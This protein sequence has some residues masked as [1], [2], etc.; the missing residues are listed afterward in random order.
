[1]LNRIL[2]SSLLVLL[3]ACGSQPPR[4]VETREEGGTVLKPSERITPPAAVKRGGGY[5][6]D[7]GPGDDEPPPEVLAAI[8]DAVPRAE[9]LHRFA[10]KPY[11]VLGKDYVPLPPGRTYKVN[12]IASWYGKKF[13]G[14]KTSSGE[15]YDM[16]GMTAA[17]TVLPIP[18]YVRVTAQGSGKSVVLRVNDRGPFHADRIIDL[19]YTAAWKLGLI[20][21]GSGRVTVELLDPSRELAASSAPA[22]SEPV[23]ASN[24]PLVSPPVPA[25]TG[26]LAPG[27]YVQLGAFGNPDNAEAFRNHM[28]REFDWLS[29]RLQ[30]VPGGNVMR[31]QAGPFATRAEAEALAEKV[32]T[33]TGVKPTIVTR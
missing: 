16:Y 33:A 30:L 10:N 8:P 13:H 7:D 18:S 23:A 11:N 26:A 12:G 28:A 5:Y 6:K 4:P 19:S 14:Q 17:H 20:G 24:I 31:V 15:L 27:A 32:R 25:S 29:E 1:M 22:P 3:A 21:N 9:P 2:L